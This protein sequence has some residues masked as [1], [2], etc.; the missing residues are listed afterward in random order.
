MIYTYKRLT[1]SHINLQKLFARLMFRNGQAFLVNA[2]HTQ[3]IF[4]D[5]SATLK[6]K[7][8]EK[9]VYCIEQK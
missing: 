2:C 5:L 8:S 4:Q 7:K 6:A 1:R 9:E 3:R